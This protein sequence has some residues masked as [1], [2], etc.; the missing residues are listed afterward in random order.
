MYKM[1]KLL[2]AIRGDESFNVKEA[3]QKN[4]INYKSVVSLLQYAEKKGLITK[5]TDR[6]YKLT[7][8]GKNRLILNSSMFE[9]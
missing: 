3:A 7:E 1:D 5:T 6:R 8:E 4:D 9:E 2:E